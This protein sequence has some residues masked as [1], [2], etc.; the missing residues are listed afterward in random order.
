[1]KNTLSS[2]PPPLW[3]FLLLLLLLLLIPFTSSKKSPET[4]IHHRLH[5]HHCATATISTPKHPH[6]PCL[7]T[8]TLHPRRPPQPPLPPQHLQPPPPPEE[9]DPRYGVAKR[10]VPSGPNPL[11]N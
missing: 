3:K 4:S 6:P 5:D 2:T 8:Q 10:L 9:I 1:M 7:Q 11:H